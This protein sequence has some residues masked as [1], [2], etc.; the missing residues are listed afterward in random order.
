MDRTESRLVG[1]AGSLEYADLPVAAVHAAKLRVID[2]LGVALAASHAPT[3]RAVARLAPRVSRGRRARL[4]GSLDW[5][6][7]EDAAMVNGAMVRY[8][9]MSDA[10]LSASTAHP[11]DNLPALMAVAEAHGCSGQDLLLAMVICYEVHLRICEVVPFFSHGWDQA[12]A[13]APA[14]SLGVARMLA[15]DPPT[16][17]DALAIA[18]TANIATRQTRAGDLSAWKGLAGPAA[19]KAGVSAVMMAREGITGPQNSFDGEF[20]LWRQAMAKRYR[21]PL[22]N[23]FGK[24]TF[25]VQQT[26]IKFFPMRDAVQVPVLAG[27]ALRPLLNAKG[28]PKVLT[29]IRVHSYRHAFE[30]QAEDRAFWA[31]QT[32][33]SAD[34]S[35]PFGIAVALLDGDVTPA[36]FERARYRD[37]DVKAMMKCISL[38]FDPAY[39]RRAPSTRSC[40]LTATL[41][42][43]EQLCVSEV[44]SAADI[45]RGPGDDAVERKFL[46]LTEGHL[47]S[48]RQRALLNRLWRLD[49]QT[50][51]RQVISLTGAS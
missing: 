21:I 32:R 15:L 17:R 6:T 38:E 36:T 1:F 37:P 27:L 35:L 43:G 51:L 26:N 5:T 39:D 20:G 18:T 34:H 42:G 10:F 4:F 49:A 33:E 24:H 25:G 30:R 11:S 46:A 40:R 2:S 3:V 16:M 31:P 44:Q 50:S 19:A 28:G 13:A 45:V 48:R 22:P 14:V 29:A 23:R 47:G 8:L 12:I 7:P 9:D 41:R